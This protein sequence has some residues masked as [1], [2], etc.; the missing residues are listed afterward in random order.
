[1]TTDNY[2]W[3]L[4]EL[5]KACIEWLPE[6]RFNLGVERLLHVDP[7]QMELIN[8]LAAL[9]G[10]V[11]S[12]L[13]HH[14]TPEERQSTLEGLRNARVDSMIEAM[15]SIRGE[16]PKEAF[17]SEKWA[18][19]SYALEYRDMMVHEAMYVGIDRTQ[20]LTNATAHV[21]F[22]LLDKFHIPLPPAARNRPPNNSE[23]GSEVD[24]TPATLTAP[25]PESLMQK[26]FDWGERM[27]SL[28]ISA[29]Y[30]GLLAVWSFMRDTMCQ[31]TEF[32][33]AI[34]IVVSLSLYV[35]WHAFNM[36]RMNTASFQFSEAAKIP[37]NFEAAFKE[38]SKKIGN[39]HDP[40]TRIWVKVLFPISLYSA[41]LGAAIMTS[42]FVHGL[43]VGQGLMLATC[44]R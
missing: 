38:F 13:V 16:A 12:W 3:H 21:T 23:A 20:A 26:M 25:S 18:V 4:A 27:T 34:T 11:R 28:L 41:L 43:L 39:P 2:E 5:S 35:F 30:V 6:N 24:S 33:V 14:T 40:Y 19:F 7:S 36:R 44:P 29:G 9:E 15:L 8:A 31:T 42:A 1:M 32:A 22:V 10:V 37:D 17:G